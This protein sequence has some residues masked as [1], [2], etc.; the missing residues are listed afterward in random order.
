MERKNKKSFNW[1]V[2]SVGTATFDV[3][4]KGYK[5]LK[6]KSGE[7]PELQ[8]FP[9]GTKVEAPE[10]AFSSGGGATNTAVTFAKQGL[11]TACVFEIGDDEFGKLVLAEMKKADVTVFPSI[12]KKLPTA[13]SSILIDESGER[14]VFVSR[15]AS[16]DLKLSEIPLAKLE[17]DWVYLVPGIMPLR[18]VEILLERFKK[19][20]AKIA[21]NPSKNLI[22]SGLSK[23]KKVLSQTDV[24]L[25]NHEE[26]AFLTGLSVKENKKIFKVLDEK[27]QG[28]LVVT[29]G[30][31]GLKVSDGNF[32]WQAEIFK[33]K[34]VI[35]RLGAG[36]A[37]GS[38]FVAGLIQAGEVCQK[39]ACNPDKI[40]YAIRLG[41][42]NATSMVESIG[43]KTGILSKKEFQNHVRWKNLK[44]KIEKI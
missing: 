39:G 5:S 44:I 16:G 4:L 43:A 3:Y 7:A 15:G 10:F 13:F 35:D 11:K 28:I 25:L 40:S 24:L 41:S 9:L 2:V 37:F 19:S 17:T 22:L 34:K 6:I 27:V 1:D 38:G 32:L 36:D 12:N 31:R 8:C 42:A 20:G 29:D 23:L 14:T 33:E 18:Q 21:L 30:Q 26:A